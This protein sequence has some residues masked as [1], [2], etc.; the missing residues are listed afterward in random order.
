M[1]KGF[2]ADLHSRLVG[3]K[4]SE[5]QVQ[6]EGGVA[7]GL[8]DVFPIAA[9]H[10]ERCLGLLSPGD[11]LLQGAVDLFQLEGLFLKLADEDLAVFFHQAQFL[12]L[13]GPNGCQF[14]ALFFCQDF[15]DANPERFRL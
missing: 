14:T 11:I 3:C 8:K 6:D 1:V 5:F 9:G 4:N 2:A 10:L 15:L 13:W 7:Y 12:T